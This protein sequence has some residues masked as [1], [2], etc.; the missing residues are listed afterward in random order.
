[1]R[2]QRERGRIRERKGP[3]TELSRHTL[4]ASSTSRSPGPSLVWKTMLFG[5][6]EQQQ[7]LA[8]SGMR[9]ELRILGRM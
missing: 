2:S 5:H 3:G 7:K 9:K 6:K 4:L 1:M 8:V